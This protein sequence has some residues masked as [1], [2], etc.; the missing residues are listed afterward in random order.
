MV[1]E[2]VH[3]R[4]PVHHVARLGRDHVARRLQRPGHLE[5]LVGRAHQ[6]GAPGLGVAVEQ[7]QKRRRRLDGVR[8]ALPVL[9]RDVELRLH[10]HLL[11]PP[12]HQGDELGEVRHLERLLVRLPLS[13]VVRHALEH[14]ARD[15]DLGV[16]FGEEEIGNEHKNVRT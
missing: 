5:V 10:E 6:R 15:G 4:L 12:R 7:L 11:D 9:R 13:S 14:R 1:D 8:R 16:E 3:D 2:M